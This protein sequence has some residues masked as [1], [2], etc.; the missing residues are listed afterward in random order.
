M[1][2]P[3]VR[4]ASLILALVEAQTGD[5]LWFNRVASSGADLRSPKGDAD[6]VDLVMKGFTEE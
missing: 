6:M 2:A 4:P 1:V 3:P 5:V